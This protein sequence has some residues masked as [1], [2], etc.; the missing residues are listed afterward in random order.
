M[1]FNDV[2]VKIIYLTK[3][4]NI[5]NAELG[6]IIGVERQAMSGRAERN[7]FFKAQEIEKIEKHFNI[8]LSSANI[9]DNSFERQNDIKIDEKTTGFGKRLKE[10][11][12]K[13]NFLDSEMAHLLE[14][15]P[16]NYKEL[17]CEAQYINLNILNRIKQNFKVSIDWLIYGD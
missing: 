6:K 5:S 12:K 9:S 10:L 8:K 4:N 2:L 7:S 17:S 11:Q 15:T 14:I 3:R 16:E 13:H 1:R